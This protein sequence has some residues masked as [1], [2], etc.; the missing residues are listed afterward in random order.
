MR[1]AVRRTLVWSA[2]VA[3]AGGCAAQEGAPLPPVLPGATVISPLFGELFA[4]EVP[5]GFK[6]QSEQTRGD[7]H[8][9]TLVIAT[10]PNVGPWTQRILVSA[11]KDLGRAPEPTAKAMAIRIGQGFQSAC[12]TTFSGGSVLD[13]MI[14]TGQPAHAILVGCGSHK[15]T[16]SGAATSEMA[17]IAVIKS[18]RNIYSIQWS[19]RGAPQT[20][21][22]QLDAGLWAARL[23]SLNPMR[24][25]EIVPGEAAPYPSCTK[26]R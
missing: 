18:G 3:F 13:G 19:E 16:T 25:C 20:T 21:A 2:L 4:H 10:D 26:G 24:V 14:A 6:P 1:A 8:M 7:V 23:K 9:R 17:V 11:S 12:P 22:L 15:Q 5:A